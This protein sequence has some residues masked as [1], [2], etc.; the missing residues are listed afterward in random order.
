MRSSRGTRLNPGNPNFSLEIL[1]E[2]RR[3]WDKFK[4]WA[5]DQGLE[6]ES[7][8]IESRCPIR[9]WKTLEDGFQ[10][11]VRV[12]ATSVPVNSSDIYTT[13]ITGFTKLRCRIRYD[14]VVKSW[15]VSPWPGA[16]AASAFVADCMRRG[17]KTLVKL[18]P[19]VCPKCLK[20]IKEAT[21]QD[22]DRSAQHMARGMLQRKTEISRTYLE[23]DNKACQFRWG[24]PA[25]LPFPLMKEGRLR[26]QSDYACPRDN[27]ML[28]WWEGQKSLT[29]PMGPH[30]DYR[31]DAA[32]VMARRLMEEGSQPEDDIEL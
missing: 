8:T 11:E 16:E 22:P 1:P 19:K 7:E 4:D 15:T 23:C 27:Q 26:F 24:R 9:L 30:C 25:E 17:Q 10:M 18:Y 12:R 32:A 2:V 13:M 20:V 6:V 31:R 14:K 21:E 3:D 5:Q 28:V 29:C